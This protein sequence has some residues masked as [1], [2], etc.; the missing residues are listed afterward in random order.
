MGVF[1]GEE[2]SP[3]R[4][5]YEKKLP[6]F[7]VGYIGRSGRCQIPGHRMDFDKPEY[8]AFPCRKAGLK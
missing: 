5:L 3:S 1:T 7:R 2:I 4:Y 6:P 8:I